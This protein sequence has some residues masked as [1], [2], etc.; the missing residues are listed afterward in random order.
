MSSQYAGFAASRG[1]NGKTTDFFHTRYQ[2]MPWFRVDLGR[3]Y[4]VQRVVLYNRKDCCGKL[5]MYLI[6]IKFVLADQST[7]VFRNPNPIN[8]INKCILFWKNHL[9]KTIASSFHISVNVSFDFEYI[10]SVVWVIVD[11]CL[12]EVT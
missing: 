11:S 5:Y 8:L 10:H 7:R 3:S 4:N 9:A 1:V 6:L 12:L 2:N